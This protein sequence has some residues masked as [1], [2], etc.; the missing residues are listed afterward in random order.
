MPQK[1]ARNEAIRRA[2]EKLAAD[3]ASGRESVEQRCSRLGL[4]MPLPTDGSPR[5]AIDFPLFGSSA[6]LDLETLS[7]T[8]DAGAERSQTDRILFYHYFL[9]DGII[10]AGGE[11]IS[12]RELTG[13]AFYWEPFR[14]RTCLPLAKKFGDDYARL[15]SALDRF[16]WSEVAAGDFGARV[17]GFGELYLSLVAWSAEEGIA[18]EI[19]V[20]FDPAIK[21]VYEAED[22]AVF[23]SR[24]CL[25]LLEA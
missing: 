14:S 6:R 21:R 22:A 10:R 19:S 2:K 13:G 20:L 18:G 3:L 23:A 15:R 5:G 11:L 24:I 9:S 8:D 17:H 12:F 7:L 25:K 16:T 1:E 4:P